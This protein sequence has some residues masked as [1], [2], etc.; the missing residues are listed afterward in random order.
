MPAT[1]LV[2]EATTKEETPT[3]QLFERTCKFVTRCLLN[4]VHAALPHEN[5]SALVDT[6]TFVFQQTLDGTGTIRVAVRGVELNADFVYSANVQQCAYSHLTPA[7][8]V[9]RV[10]IDSA[11]DVEYALEAVVALLCVVLLALV[12]HRYRT[13]DRSQAQ[14]QTQSS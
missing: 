12:V 2:V 8:L 14:T 10:A 3:V 13:F 9:Q 7:Y 5:C 6:K 4:P 11:E 1:L